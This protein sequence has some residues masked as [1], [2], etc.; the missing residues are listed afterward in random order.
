[1]LS[2]LQLVVRLVA[3][4]DLVCGRKTARNVFIFNRSVR[5]DARGACLLQATNRNADSIASSVV[6]GKVM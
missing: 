3:A 2:A 5:S 4:N 6:G 1:M